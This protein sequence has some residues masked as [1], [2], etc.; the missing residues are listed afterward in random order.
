VSVSGIIISALSIQ[1]AVFATGNYR[2]QGA[3]A[4]TAAARSSLADMTPAEPAFAP[5]FVFRD[6]A[7]TAI[8]RSL[9]VLVLEALASLTEGRGGVSIIAPKD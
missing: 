2:G 1:S 5:G 6:A 9:L 8:A 7:A 3:W 4:L